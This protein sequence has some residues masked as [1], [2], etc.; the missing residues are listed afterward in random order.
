MTI[1]FR[2]VGLEELV[3]IQAS[4]MAAFPPRLPGQPFFYPVLNEAYATQIARDWNTRAG[5]RAGFVTRFAVDEA[6]AARFARRVVGSRTHEELWVP[7]EEMDAF[8]AHILG[9]IGVTSAFFGEPYDGLPG[10]FNLGGKT[11]AEQL[12]ALDGLEA[13]SRFDFS[14]EVPANQ[15][16]VFA[17]YFYW[18]HP[19]ARIDLEAGRR[20]R[21]LGLVREQWAASTCASVSLGVAASGA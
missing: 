4:G 10:Q 18:E 5:S 15:S 11:A 14:Y 17:N 8:N 19:D 12:V 21:I 7:A 20:E 16:A 2:P 6:Y 9:T 3:L 1:L 13:Y